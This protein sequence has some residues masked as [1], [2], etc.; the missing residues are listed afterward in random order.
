[1]SFKDKYGNPAISYLLIFQ[2]RGKE[3]SP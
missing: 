2:T 1:L 3:S